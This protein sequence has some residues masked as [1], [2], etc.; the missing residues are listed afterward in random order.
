[1]FWGGWSCGKFGKFF[2]GVGSGIFCGGW[3][4]CDTCENGF[5]NW[6]YV[7]CCICSCWAGYWIGAGAGW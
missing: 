3:I 2:I 7:C 4:G 1:M 6:L 5:P